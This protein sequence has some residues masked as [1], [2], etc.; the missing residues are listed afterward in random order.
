MGIILKQS[1]EK[2][3]QITSHAF[4]YDSI[5]GNKNNN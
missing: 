4:Q 1:I 2:K 5:T 3:S